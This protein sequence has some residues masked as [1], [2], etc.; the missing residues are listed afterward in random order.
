M[1]FYIREKSR[2]QHF[3]QKRNVT[4][5]DSGSKKEESEVEF[6]NCWLIVLHIPRLMR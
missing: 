6:S 3:P 5:T 4:Q 1:T 2:L